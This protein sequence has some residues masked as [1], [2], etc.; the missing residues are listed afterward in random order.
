MDRW[1]LSWLKENR[2]LL[3]A[4]IIGTPLVIAWFLYFYFQTHSAFALVLIAL[5]PVFAVVNVLINRSRARQ[6]D[7]AS[8]RD[9]PTGTSLTPV[10]Y[11]PYHPYV[12]TARWVG[13]ADVPGS[14][15]RM[16][17][18]TPLPCWSCLTVCSPFGSGHT[19]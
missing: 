6:G 13:A 3:I 2:P 14:L 4:Q 12:P 9:K 15:G 5:L 7:P 16:N 11:V 18:S 17:A 10:A 19:S 8:R 1:D